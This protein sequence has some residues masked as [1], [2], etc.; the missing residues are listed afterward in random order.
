MTTPESNLGFEIAGFPVEDYSGVTPVVK[1]EDFN[2]RR[3][4]ALAVI[5]ATI[6]V[7]AGLSAIIPA[8]ADGGGFQ[9]DM[10]RDNPGWNSHR[11]KG[12]AILSQP[13]CGQELVIDGQ[14]VKNPVS[15]RITGKEMDMDQPLALVVTASS[16]LGDGRSDKV[17]AV[18][19]QDSGNLAVNFNGFARSIENGQTLPLSAEDVLDISIYEADKRSDSGEEIK[20][21]NRVLNSTVKFICS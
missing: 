2:R 20:L 11:I 3:R 10:Y 15:F 16:Y 17:T 8:K 19:G 18:Y 4:N 7:V 13:H 12:A 6:A 5:G 21:G 9:F 14:V 1:P